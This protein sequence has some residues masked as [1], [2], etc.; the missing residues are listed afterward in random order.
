VLGGGRLV[1]IVSIDN[2]REF[3]LVQAVE[4]G[5]RLAPRLVDA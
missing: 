3:V 1:G 2:V 4:E 5:K